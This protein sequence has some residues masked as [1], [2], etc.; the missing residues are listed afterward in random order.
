[1]TDAFTNKLVHEF[2]EAAVWL[3]GQVKLGHFKK[4]S[5]N[6]LREYVRCKTGLRF[7]NSI[8]PDI[9]RSVIR[10]RPDLAPWIE[11]GALKADV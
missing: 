7:S 10:R 9:L 2:T 5:S 8:S 6:F 4:F 1:M 3:V 11:I